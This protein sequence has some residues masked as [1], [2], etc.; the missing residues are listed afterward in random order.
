[1]DLRSSV[2]KS[3]FRDLAVRKAAGLHVQALRSGFY[4]AA[5]VRIATDKM[6]GRV[7]AIVQT[8][9]G[10]AESDVGQT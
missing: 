6:W 8:A 7:Q 10:H 3:I 9:K 2:F 5:A 4:A 1:M